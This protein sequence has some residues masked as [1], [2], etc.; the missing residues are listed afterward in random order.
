MWRRATI[1]AVKPDKTFVATNICRNK[2]NFCRDK[3]I[4]S[5][6]NF[7]RSEHTFIVTKDVFRHDKTFVATRFVVTKMIPVAAPA[8]NWPCPLAVIEHSYTSGPCCS[9]LNSPVT[10]HPPPQPLRS[11]PFMVEF[12]THWTSKTLREIQTPMWKHSVKETAINKR[13]SSTRTRN[14]FS[15]TFFICWS[16]LRKTSFE[17][18]LCVVS[19]RCVFNVVVCVTKGV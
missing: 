3:N 16:L 8:N 11:S 2:H 13:D 19:V 4:L 1:R 17:V 5:R 14:W 10:L 6:Q 12:Q 15:V 7:C 9:V 18:C